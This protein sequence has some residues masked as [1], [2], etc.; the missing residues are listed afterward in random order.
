MAVGI[1][2]ALLV[3]MLAHSQP[4]RHPGLYQASGGNWAQGD[5]TLGNGNAV[6]LNGTTATVGIYYGGTFIELLGPLRLSSGSGLTLQGAGA[7]TAAVGTGTAGS[8]TGISVG[9][10]GYIRPFVHRISVDNT[11]LTAAATTDVTIWTTAVNTRILRL[12]ADVTTVFT[13]G[14]LTSMTVMCGSSAGGNQYLLANSVFTAVNT[15]GD[16]AAEIG[17]GLLSAT[18]ADMGTSA[19]GVPGA[20][21]VQ[22]RFTCGGANCN[23]ATQGTVTFLLEG[24][25][26]P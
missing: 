14:G 12:T 9:S 16:V 13:G 19:S 3:A 26:Y 24:V 2:A 21:T 25:V 23:A 15:W 17:A 8:G 18:V 20:I 22:C 1:A 4:A 10:T 7:F 5:L 6:W 11:A